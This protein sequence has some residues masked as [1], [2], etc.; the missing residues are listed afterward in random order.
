M[1]KFLLSSIS[2]FISVLM[3]YITH[4]NYKNKYFNKPELFFWLLCWF[5]VIFLS[6]RPSSV[7]NFFITNFNLSIFYIVNIISIAVLVI[8]T[9]FNYLKTKILE[10]KINKIIMIDSIKKIKRK[11][12]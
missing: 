8:F 1:I 4:L 11:I 5:I 9:Y 2:I 7:D 12:K 3:I 10:K 6:I